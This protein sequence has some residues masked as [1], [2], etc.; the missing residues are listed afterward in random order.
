VKPSAIADPNASAKFEIGG[1]AVASPTMPAPSIMA[2]AGAPAPVPAAPAVTV[3]WP[4]PSPRTAITVQTD[5]RQPPSVLE[6]S[7]PWSMFRMLEAGSLQVRGE[8]ATATFIV[9]GRE[10]N[11]Q[12]TSAS[13]R[14][15]LNLSTLREFHCPTGI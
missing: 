9:G 11:Y 10:V 4:G 7:G 14:N 2:P 12:I 3:Q 15:P 13:T 1:S 8:A 5:P 6:R